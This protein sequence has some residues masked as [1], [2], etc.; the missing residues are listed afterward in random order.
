MLIKRLRS[1]VATGLLGTALAATLTAAAHADEPSPA[2]SPGTTVV[3][4]TAPGAPHCSATVL[5]VKEKDGRLV[6]LKDGKEV[7]AEEI[8]A[9]PAIPATPV[10]GTVPDGNGRAPSTLADSTS[11]EADGPSSQADDSSAE[12]GKTDE[13]PSFTT[14]ADASGKA[15]RGVPSTIALTCAEAAP[16][17]K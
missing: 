12:A 8:E 13:G 14:R 17:R 3:V 2:P 5:T 11:A 6:V 15:E 16:E 10:E 1:A 7:D 4:T 9:V